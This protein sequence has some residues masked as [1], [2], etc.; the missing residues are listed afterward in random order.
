VGNSDGKF[1]IRACRKVNFHREDVCRIQVAVVQQH[2]R[3]RP[4]GQLSAQCLGR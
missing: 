2:S 3:R 1:K 4:G